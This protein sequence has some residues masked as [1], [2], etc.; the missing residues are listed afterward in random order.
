MRLFQTITGSTTF[1]RRAL[2]FKRVVVAALCVFLS[3]IAFAEVRY[4]LTPVAGTGIDRDKFRAYFPRPVAHVAI[5]PTNNAGQPL[6]GWALVVISDSDLS[7]IDSDPLIEV[8][9]DDLLDTE[10]ASLPPPVRNRI[11]NGLNRAG[12]STDIYDNAVTLRDIVEGVGTTLEPTFTIGKN[13]AN[14]GQNP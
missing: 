5:I 11:R 4:A 8:L 1:L 6:F 7:D 10:V 9:S 3:G 2:I 14:R 13:K 12:F